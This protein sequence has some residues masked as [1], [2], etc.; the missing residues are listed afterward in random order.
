MR[1]RRPRGCVC[2]QAAARI[3]RGR[4]LETG[5]KKIFGQLREMGILEG[6]HA[7]RE[8]MERGLIREEL[9]EFEYG[10]EGQDVYTR[11]FITRRGLEEIEKKLR[12][13]R[14]E[15]K[16]LEL[17]VGDLKLGF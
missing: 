13:R 6:R 3:L 5:G 8:A 15:V 4:G 2:L 17:G 7:R 12:R 11:V 9:G 1:A 14:W 16:E 10:G